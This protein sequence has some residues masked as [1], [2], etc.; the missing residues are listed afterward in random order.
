MNTMAIIIALG[1]QRAKKKG[2]GAIRL[3]CNKMT[4]SI[5]TQQFI[6][7]LILAREH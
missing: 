5:L 4:T 1:T 7:K 6:H 3:N 2:I